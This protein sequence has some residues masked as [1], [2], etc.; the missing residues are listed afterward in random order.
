MARRRGSGRYTKRIKLEKPIQI[1]NSYNELEETW[2]TVGERWAN[3][4]P[5]RSRELL[6][7]GQV[8]EQINHRVEIRYIKDLDSTWRI[9]Y[10]DKVLNIDSVINVEDRNRYLELVCIEE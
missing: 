10:R 5:M 1:K 8:N 4:I 3:V 9:V 7:A 2:Q 6:A